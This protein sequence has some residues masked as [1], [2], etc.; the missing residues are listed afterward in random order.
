MPSIIDTVSRSQAI[1]LDLE[2]SGISKMTEERVNPTL[3]QKY[4]DA[5][6][7]A[8]TFAVLQLGLTCITWQ[9]ETGSYQTKTFNVP[10]TP[11]ILGGD[12]ISDELASKVEREICFSSKTISFLQSHDFKLS[13]VFDKGVP[14]LSDAEATKGD[15]AKF[16]EQ[17]TLD[18]HINIHEC[19]QETQNFYK[20]MESRI[21]AWLT[22]QVFEEKPS[23]SLILQNPYQG[24]FRPIQKRLI[25]QLVET[26][27]LGYRAHNKNG[28]MYMEIRLRN[29]NE[30]SK[31]GRYNLAKRRQAVAKQTG[32]RYLWEA[33]RGGKFA[34]KIDPDLIVG[35]NPEMINALRQSLLECESRLKKC[36]PVIVGH[37]MLWDLCFLFKTFVGP[38]PESLDTFQRLVKDNLPKIVDTKY[39]CTRGGHEMM[40]DQSLEE[41]FNS[42]K[43]EAA[44][45][46]K[47]ELMY[48]YDKAAPHDAGY[49]SKSYSH[50]P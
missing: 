38:L 44:P 5:R 20:M 13:Q 31:A 6:Q 43:G 14:F 46:V 32:A 45:L 26:R 8:E 16:L 28:N 37:N 24:R 7:A 17:K 41:C 33:L 15:V 34:I 25:H 50:R 29:P 19:P 27:F 22:D 18:T 21:Q 11:A 9:A 48:S 10:L 35:E 49:D 30:D 47:T 42:V 12:K 36:R 2:M 39:L 23:K 40:P 1:S 4:E 3:K